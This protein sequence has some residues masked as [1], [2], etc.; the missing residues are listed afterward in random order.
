MKFDN[1]KQ[2]NFTILGRSDRTKS[3]RPQQP[4]NCGN[5]V[6]AVREYKRIVTMVYK[7]KWDVR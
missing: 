2:S 6:C 1:N 7:E 5:S 4:V 3:Q